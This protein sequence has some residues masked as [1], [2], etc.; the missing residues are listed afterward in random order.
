MAGC[1][2]VRVVDTFSPQADR[3]ILEALVAAGALVGMMENTV[4]VRKD[5]LKGFEFDATHCPD[6][7]PPLVALAC[8]C[9]G[10]TVT[11]R[12]RTAGAQGK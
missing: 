7:F 4:T 2:T 10:T 1:V 3:R 6:L 5:K 12:C 9:E 11:Y 8:N